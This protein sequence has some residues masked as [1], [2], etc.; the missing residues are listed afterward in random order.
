MLISVSVRNGFAFLY[1]ISW[2]LYSEAGD[3]ILQANKYK[4]D[5]GCYSEK[6]CADTA[7]I[8]IPTKNRNFCIRNNCYLVCN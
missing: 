2:D 8:S 3:L 5:Y 6:I 1:R 7:S 4:Q